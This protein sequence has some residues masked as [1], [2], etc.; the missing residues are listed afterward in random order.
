MDRS[1]FTTRYPFDLHGVTAS[2]DRS[3][4]IV[5]CDNSVIFRGNSVTVRR[6]S[7][8][9]RGHSVIFRANAVAVRVRNRAL[10][11]RSAASRRTCGVFCSADD[12]FRLECA[13][14][15]GSPDAYRH[16][17]AWFRLDARADRGAA[18][19]P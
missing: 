15:R 16:D 2:I 9:A 14:R 18:R 7:V 6:N 5:F 8:A 10:R 17:S 1:I 13:V 19:T 11:A 12:R 3:I 4:F